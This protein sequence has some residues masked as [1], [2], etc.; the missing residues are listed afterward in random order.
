MSPKPRRHKLAEHLTF[1]AE[2]A[3]EAGKITLHYF[4]KGVAV[5]AKADDS[6]VTVAD[7]ETEKFLRDAIAAKFPDHGILGEEHGETNPGARWRWILDP[8][9][10]TQAFIH[11]VPL[12]TTLIALE[13]SGEP[14]LGVI[15]CPP[16]AETVAAAVGYGCTWNNEPCRVS[17][18]DKLEDARLNLTEYNVFLRKYPT[19]GAELLRSVRLTR[20]WSD[21]YAYLL[22]ATGRAEI[23]LDPVMA[24]WD[25][26]PLLPIIEEAGGKFTDFNGTPTINGGSGIATNGRL[27]RAVLDAVKSEG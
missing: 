12:Y 10:G 8:I 24:L 22:V 18:I 4:R 5:D 7:R 16:L 9:D 13:C 2:L 14:A 26:A 6:P 19:G 25:C 20:G 17:E 23:A 15:H 3:A 21:A 27:H 1:A 11:G